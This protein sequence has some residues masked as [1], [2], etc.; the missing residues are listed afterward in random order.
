MQG[1]PSDIFRLY[2]WR[3]GASQPPTP[4]PAEHP[5]TRAMAKQPGRAMFLLAPVATRPFM[6]TLEARA[7]ADLKDSEEYAGHGGLHGHFVANA[8]LPKV[9][10]LQER[11]EALA[12]VR[13]RK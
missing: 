3:G 1:T 7:E 11:E 13:N 6:R 5:L 9:E 2:N 10:A 4:A 8:L 12:Q